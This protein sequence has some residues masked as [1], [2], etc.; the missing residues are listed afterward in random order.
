MLLSPFP[1]GIRL[2]C[3]LT[4]AVLVV[5]TLDQQGDEEHNG[6]PCACLLSQLYLSMFPGSFHL[7]AL[8]LLNLQAAVR[9]SQSV[10]M[11]Q[12][13]FSLAF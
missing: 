4:T 11:L 1:F 8:W 12:Y 7:S 3:A 10:G 2:G 13:R 6:A 5:L 9:R